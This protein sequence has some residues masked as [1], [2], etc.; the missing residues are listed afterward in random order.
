[1]NSVT[2]TPQTKKVKRNAF[3]VLEDAAKEQ[4]KLNSIQ[5]CRFEFPNTPQKISK[6]GR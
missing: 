1:M 6:K 3:E 2:E 5:K 4:V